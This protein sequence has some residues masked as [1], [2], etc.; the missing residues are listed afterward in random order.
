MCC[1]AWELSG[2]AVVCHSPWR[3]WCCAAPSPP[4]KQS[5]VP[6]Q[7]HFRKKPVTQQCRAPPP[8][9]STCKAPAAVQRLQKHHTNH[10]LSCPYPWD[11]WRWSRRMRTPERCPTSASLLAVPCFCSSSLQCPD[12][13]QPHPF[14]GAELSG[15]SQ[16]ICPPF[17]SSV[18]FWVFLPPKGSQTESKQ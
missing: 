13:T 15:N 10:L 1:S 17:L 8:A 18:S 14:S 6:A 2:E 11:K 12:P 16:G 3:C 9:G 5:S 4:T 7:C